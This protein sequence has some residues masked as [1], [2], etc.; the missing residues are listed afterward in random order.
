MAADDVQ[1]IHHAR[2]GQVAGNAQ[3]LFGIDAT[4]HGLVGH[5]AHPQNEVRPDPRPDGLDH[6]QREAHPVLHGSAIRT[7][8]RVGGGGPELVHQVA[9]GFEFHTINA[10]GVHALGRVGVVAD[11]ARNVPVFHLLG[12]SAVRGLALVRG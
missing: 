6:V 4:W 5:A 3:A 7:L 1:K 9:I 12:E 11:Q 10:G 8:Q 2:L